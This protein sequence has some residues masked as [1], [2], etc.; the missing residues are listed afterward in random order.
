M[1]ESVK[2]SVKSSVKGSVTGG[3]KGNVG[4]KTKKWWNWSLF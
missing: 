4:L 3:T 2:N 1:K